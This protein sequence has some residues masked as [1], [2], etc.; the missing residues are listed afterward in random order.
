MSLDIT[1]YTDM[2]PHALKSRILEVIEDGPFTAYEDWKHTLPT[3]QFVTEILRDMG[4]HM[5]VKSSANFR[6]RK[7]TLTKSM[8][9]WSACLRIYQKNKER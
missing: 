7:E 1:L 4:I 8:H 6:I 5:T 3:G 9:F 2:T